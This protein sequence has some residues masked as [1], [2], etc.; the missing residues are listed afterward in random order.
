MRPPTEAAPVKEE[1]NMIDPVRA[2]MPDRDSLWGGIEACVSDLPHKVEWQE[3]TRTVSLMH[4]TFVIPYHVVQ[5][6]SQADDLYGHC[7]ALAQRRGCRF[8]KANDGS[9]VF[10]KS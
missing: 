2:T 9:Y 10:Q 8:F 4:T 3:G 1:L 6:F 7:E 5:L